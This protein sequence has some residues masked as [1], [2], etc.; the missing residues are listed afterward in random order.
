MSASDDRD[1][2]DGLTQRYRDASAEDTRRPSA[3]VRDAVRAHAEMFAASRVPGAVNAPGDSAAPDK[4]PAATA[5]QAANQSRWKLS[6]VASI[7]LAGLTGLVVLQFDRGT[8]EEKDAAFGQPSPVTAPAAP[9]P[10]PQATPAPPAP[11]TPAPATTSGRASTAPA[12]SAE[13]PASTTQKAKAAPARQSPA[14]A[15]ARP[16]LQATQKAAPTAARDNN[17]DRADAASAGSQAVPPAVAAPAPAA[18]S[19]FPASPAPPA[20]PSAPMAAPAAPAQAPEHMSAPAGRLAESESANA[21][22]PL[23]DE[24]AAGAAAAPAAPPAALRKA[25]PLPRA[26]A[27]ARARDLAATLQHAASTG[28]TWQVGQLVGQGA[29]INASDDAGRTPLM[30]AVI[31]GHTGTV[32]RLLAL[33]ASTAPAD[34]DGLTALQHAQRLGLERIAAL[35]AASR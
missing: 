29:P 21:T 23:S 27:L 8:P 4:T 26:A 12:A 18:E 19:A 35:L 17:A 3:H 34:R 20:M 22:R 28:R 1:P 25:A 14:P 24:A 32:Q 2:I 31:Y 33:G 10:A 13:A 7:A 15:P 11:V 30:L 9:A 6:L 5:P 16:T